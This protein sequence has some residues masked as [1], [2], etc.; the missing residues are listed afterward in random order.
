MREIPQGLISFAFWCH[1]PA[2]NTVLCLMEECVCV[3]MCLC[4]YLIQNPFISRSLIFV[5]LVMV[6]PIFYLFTTSCLRFSVSLDVTPSHYLPL[7]ISHIFL[8]IIIWIQWTFKV[9]YVSNVVSYV[10]HVMLF[11]IFIPSSFFINLCYGRRGKA[12]I[13]LSSR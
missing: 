2:C 3:S 4:V 9:W 11:D 1:Q 7:A 13:L 10:V 12:F 8:R 6:C 5:W